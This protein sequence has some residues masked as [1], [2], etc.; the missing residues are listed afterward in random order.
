[1]TNRFRRAA[2]LL[3][4][5]LLGVV[6]STATAAASTTTTT[7]NSDNVGLN[8]SLATDNG[9]TGTFVAGPGTPP[10]GTGSFAFDVPDGGKT[11]LSTTIPAGKLLKAVDAVSYATY[12]DASSTMPAFLAPSLNLE[13]C[14]GGVTGGSCQG[15]T[16]LVW[17]PIYAYG[18]PANAN[19]PVDTGTWQTWDALGHTST[20][21]TGGWWSTHAINGVCA[22]NC[23]VSLATIQQDNPAAVILSFGV[24]VGHGPAGTFVGAADALTL[25]FA[26]GNTAV[27]D[28]EPTTPANEQCKDGGWTTFTTAS[29]P[30]APMFKN[31]GACVSYFAS[32]GHPHGH[33][34]GH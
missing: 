24:N 4:A 8:W 31:Q 34:P 21:Y 18:T 1:M 6:A 9:A 2:A 23:F 26:G 3:P 12:R 17:E 33:A 16:T 29:S 5:A 19:N 10:L 15:Y 27:Y 30:P 22:D 14:S 28:L 13:V 32:G 20:S 7:V 25:G 11:T